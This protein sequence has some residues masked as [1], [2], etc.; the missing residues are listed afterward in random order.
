M[1]IDITN[2]IVP[3][4]SLLLGGGS[5]FFTWKW[6]ARKSKAEAASAETT[7]TK[8]LQDVY[9]QLIADVKADRNEQKEYIQ[10]LKSDRQHL[11]EEIDRQRTRQ[12]ENDDTIRQLQRE[13]ARNGRMVEALRPFLCAEI[14]CQT[15]KHMAL[16]HTDSKGEPL[17]D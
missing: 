5:G 16:S 15:R 12:N 10:E 3:V 9:Q 4:L 8:E 2:L 7:A 6:Q 17:N 13:V 1:E 14:Q 11:R